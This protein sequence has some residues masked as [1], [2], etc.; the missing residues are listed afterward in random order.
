MTFTAPRRLRGALSAAA[1]FVADHVL[2]SPVFAY[3]ATR[4]SAMVVLPE[5]TSGR[6]PLAAAQPQPGTRHDDRVLVGAGV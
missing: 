5:T 1:S 2:D 4:G 6:R 3:P